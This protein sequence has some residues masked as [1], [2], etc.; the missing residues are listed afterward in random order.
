MSFTTLFI[1]KTDHE[2]SKAFFMV[3]YS[4]MNMIVEFGVLLL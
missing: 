4:I 2:F 3:I 1:M